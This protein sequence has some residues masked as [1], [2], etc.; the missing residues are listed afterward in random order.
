MDD[1]S[2]A[3][4]L[5]GKGWIPLLLLAVINHVLL[6]LLVAGLVVE[7]GEAAYAALTRLFMGLVFLVAIFAVAG[8]YYDRRYVATVS[9]W[10]PTR[11]YFLMFFVPLVGY[12]IT[13]LYLFRRHRR[14][15]V[16]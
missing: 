7:L 12:L 2:L 5:R 11:W 8:L 9:E 16:P 15:G 14:V 13:V 10:S 6:T 1:S 4:W 3:I